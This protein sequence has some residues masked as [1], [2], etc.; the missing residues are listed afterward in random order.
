MVRAKIGGFQ[1]ALVEPVTDE[2]GPAVETDVTIPMLQ[3]KYA[4]QAGGL[5]I[6]LAGGYQSYDVVAVN[7]DDDDVDSYIFAIGATYNM[8]PLYLAANYWMGQNTSNMGM[9]EWDYAPD[10]GA[11]FDADGI[12]DNDAYGLLGVVGFTV[13]DMLYFEGGVGYVNADLDDSEEEDETLAYY[14]QA[15]ITF[16]K[17]VF[18][19][20]EIGHFD[21]ND[22]ANGD[23][24]GD[25]TYYGLQWQVRF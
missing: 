3:A 15:K 5:G 16:A 19:V 25:V 2:I 18:I 17:G 22:D 1:F 20:P 12:L 9:A 11:G 4:F 7:D 8:G 13:S 23:D 14:I 6:Q 24:Q 21:L 10:M